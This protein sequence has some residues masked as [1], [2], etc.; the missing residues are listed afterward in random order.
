VKTSTVA[1]AGFFGENANRMNLV[2]SAAIMAVL[3]MVVLFLLLQKHFVK[4]LAS[5]SV[6]G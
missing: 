1:L 3:P 4:G 6:K 5:G 2:A